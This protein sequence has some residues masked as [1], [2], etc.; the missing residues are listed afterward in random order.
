MSPRLR[1]KEIVGDIRR[2]LDKIDPLVDKTDG[3][4]RPEAVAEIHSIT[5]DVVRRIRSKAG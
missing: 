2:T 4:I 1:G 5:A 3:D